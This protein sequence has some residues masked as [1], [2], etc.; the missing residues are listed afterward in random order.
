VARASLDISPRPELVRIARMMSVSLARRGGLPDPLLDEVRLAVGEAV[1]R[2]VLINAGRE[3]TV[4]VRLT[5]LE[6]D[7]GYEVGVHDAG[8]AQSVPAAPQDL[9]DLSPDEAL[10]SLPAG[11]DLALIAGMADELEVEADPAGGT[12]VRLRWTR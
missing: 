3:G 11:L 9:P 4:P 12:V 8:D 5:F 1:S 7:R 10:H 2:A 6:D